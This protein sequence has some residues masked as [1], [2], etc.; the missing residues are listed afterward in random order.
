MVTN[1]CDT[2]NI[3]PYY[4]KTDFAI[5]VSVIS[6]AYTLPSLGRIVTSTALSFASP[7]PLGEEVQM[8]K[9]VLSF[10]ELG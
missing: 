7:A 4:I 10:K 8:C 5:S 3:L 6:V 9:G 1:I 2:K